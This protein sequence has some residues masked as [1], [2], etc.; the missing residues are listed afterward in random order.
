MKV[1]RILTLVALALTGALAN[2]ETY[3]L[4]IGINDYPDVLDDA[5]KL[6][7]DKDGNPIDPDLRGAVNDATSM[8]DLFIAKYGVKPENAK[9]I[10]NKD[11]NE[12]GFIDGL[13][14]ILGKLKPGDQML[15]TYSGHGGQIDSKTEADGQDEVI[16]LADNKLVP[17]DLF[18]EIVKTTS[19]AGIHSTFVFDSCFSGGMARA[20]R[21]VKFLD[22]PKSYAAKLMP[23]ATQQS[24][25]GAFRPKQ[26]APA[27]GSYAFL[28]AGREDQPTI[29]ISGVKDIPDHGIFTL[30]LLAALQDDPKATLEDLVGTTNKVL[31]ELEFEQEPRGEFSSADRAAKPIILSN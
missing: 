14:W 15:F 12:K 17:D 10:T 24:I 13:K 11:A 2:A 5:G 20:G 4:C 16:V 29:D 1:R 30:F 23:A 25:R 22:L 27:K 3:A 18:A 9:L 31:K 6:A 19:E 8:R 7:K 28:F 21:R 26:A